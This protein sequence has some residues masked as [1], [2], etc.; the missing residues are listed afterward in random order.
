LKFGFLMNDTT[1]KKITASILN[2]HFRLADDPTVYW[3]GGIKGRS[4]EI[5]LQAIVTEEIRILSAVDF[6]RLAVPADK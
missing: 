2:K 4:Y 1:F 5:V 6:K 3:V